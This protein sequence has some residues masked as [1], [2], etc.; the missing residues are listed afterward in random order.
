MNR[1]LLC[2]AHEVI[3]RK[4]AWARWIVLLAGVAFAF[5][6]AA[7]AA[8]SFTSPAN[9]SSDGAG[10]FP[11]VIADSDGNVNIAYLDFVSEEPTNGVWFVRGSFSS[12]TFHPASS[13]V[14]V[15]KNAGG[16]FSMAVE[17]SCVV[18]IAYMDRVSPFSS[19]GDIFF[20]QSSDCGASFTSINI[21][22]S[23]LTYYSHRGP[24]L[25]VNNGIAQVL[26]T[27]TTDPT[28]TETT[29]L[30]A[31]RNL[32]SN[33]TPP[34]ALVTSP[35]E[36]ECLEAAAA[37]KSGNTDIVWCDGNVEFLNSVNGARPITIGPGG[38]AQF[39]VNSEGD[40]NVVWAELSSGGS[41]EFSRSTGQT[42]MFSAPKTLFA[43]Y[44]PELV[45]DKGGNLDLA[46]WAGRGAVLFSRS[47][48][49]GNNFSAP[50]TVTPSV[51]GLGSPAVVQ[52]TADSTGVVNLT[53]EYPQ[54]PEGILFSRSD[55]QGTSFS[56]PVAV[57]TNVKAAPSGVQIATDASNHVLVL[58]SEKDVFISQRDATNAANGFTISATP[59]SLT[60]LPGGS[61]TAKVTLTA[62]SGFDQAVNLSCGQLPAG[63]EC[64]F[65]PAS[66]TPST[67]GTVVNLTVTISST[68]STPGFPFT[69]N[70]ATPMISQSQDMQ[71]TVGQMTPSVTPTAAIIPLGG[72]ASFAVTVAST[73][74]F[75]GQFN[76][77]CSAPAGV[78]C[79][80]SPN[81]AF[82]PING[83]VQSIMTVQV[84]SLPAGAIPPNGPGD[85]APSSPPLTQDIV[86][87]LGWAFLF[88]SAM[89]FVW[90]RGSDS[91]HLV[92]ERMMASIV[93]RMG[94]T[95][96]LAAVMLSCGGATTTT[97]VTGTNGTSVTTGD[98]AGVPGT[99][100]V[101]GTG[102]SA[103]AGGT[104]SGGVNM[105]GSTS[106]TFP[107]TVMAQSGA[108]V[109]NVGTVSVTVP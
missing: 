60:A 7:A 54:A 3:R 16:S 98:T 31:Q 87:I 56:T 1:P 91:S 39:A 57:S 40:V 52:M 12:G 13:P 67:L 88:L 34:T 84:L 43:G 76:L 42:G 46:Y 53:W 15:S 35:N 9:V 62:A 108:S 55:I 109:V 50:V 2:T 63:A 11:Q 82:L 68:L 22:N 100:G 101:G 64:S 8:Q 24:Q 51:S 4:N 41:I 59:A 6:S 65:A 73:G 30:Y 103:G 99:G 36:M 83:R 58:W 69:V 33:F 106:V 107:L 47:T 85:N 28:S 19:L 93:V 23:A 104:T 14:R 38:E 20:A 32:A 10:N 49:G 18:D 79:T 86:T 96:A 25:V 17:S 89:A 94:V 75:A 95:V 29:L 37:P 72:K 80:F 45:V 78:T 5:S 27:S 66:V 105:P 44:D 70:V 81:S 71:I 92:R 77:F 48:D 26:W 97:K 21:T 74:G 90:L 102:G 61:A